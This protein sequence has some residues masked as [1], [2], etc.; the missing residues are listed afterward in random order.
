[1]RSILCVVMLVCTARAASAAPANPNATAKAKQILAFLEGLPAKATGRVASGQNAGVGTKVGSGYQSYVEGLATKVGKEVALLGIDYGYDCDAKTIADANLAAVKHWQKGGLVTVSVHFNNPFTGGDTWDTSG[2]D[3][4]K[5]VTPGSAA[6][7][8]W[9]GML[10]RVAAGLAALRDQGIVVLFRPLHEQNGN[11]FWWSMKGGGRAPKAEVI[12]LWK[13]IFDLYTGAKGLHNL[14]WVY[15]PNAQL[16]PSGTEST[17]YYYPG[18]S[19]VDVVGLDL[20]VDDL[21]QLDANG[22]YS[23]LVALGKPFA[24]TELGPKSQLDGSFDATQIIKGIK[25]HAPKTAFWLSWHSWS[26]ASVA[27]VDL[28]NTSGLFADPWVLTAD[29]LGLGHPAPPP[30]A[31]PAP[32]DGGSPREGGAPARDARPAADG[33]AAASKADGGCAL[34]GAGEGEPLVLLLLLVGAAASFARRLPQRTSIPR[35]TAV[36]A[37]RAARTQLDPENDGRNGSPS[38]QNAARSRE[39]RS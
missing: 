19:L 17:T 35:T 3:L 34:G 8:T 2:V 39:R 16:D 11:W 33:G 13:Q 20:Y 30:E 37:A 14:L 28:T 18:A 38:C 23:S 29:E 36:M 7:T 6:H 4:G 31:G 10:D 21:S 32:S 24:L 26:G 1:M 27:L 5:L 22:S 12:A 25:S 9:L 15:A